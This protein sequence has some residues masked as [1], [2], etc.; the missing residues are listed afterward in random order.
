M[1][2]IIRTNHNFLVY[3]G[4]DKETGYKV[5]LNGFNW[6]CGWYWGGGYLSYYNRCVRENYIKIHTHFDNVF[7]EQKLINNSYAIWKP[8][9]YFL[10]K[11]A[12]TESEWWHIKDLYK[13]FYIYMQAAE[14][15][16]YG[17]HCTN[18]DRSDKE[19]NLDMASKIND[20]IEYVII[21][22]VKK[23]LLIK[24]F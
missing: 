22:E 9:S 2:K 18:K 15:F 10:D 19:T 12:F 11:E 13:Q 17:G 14:A 20:H 7:L 5:Y 3:L 21:P 6:D 16:Q 23:A 1:D 24:E 4:I 8:L